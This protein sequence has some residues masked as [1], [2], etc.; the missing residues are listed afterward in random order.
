MRQPTNDSVIRCE[1]CGEVAI[2]RYLGHPIG[3]QCLTKF[4]RWRWTMQCTHYTSD[5]VGSR[6]PS[7]A[8]YY[9]ITPEGNRCPGTRECAAHALAAVEEYA[10]KLA[11]YWDLEPITDSDSDSDS[12]L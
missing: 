11:E 6:C 9:L 7:P 10:E 8:E 2:V 5:S 12:N 4:E 1:L 3:R